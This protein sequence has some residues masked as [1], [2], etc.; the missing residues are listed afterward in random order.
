M[1]V[2]ADVLSVDVLMTQVYGKTGMSHALA[3][4]VEMRCVFAAES[5]SPFTGK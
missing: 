2:M 4:C 3:A 1:P 5:N